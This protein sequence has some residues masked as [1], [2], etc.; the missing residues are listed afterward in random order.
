MEWTHV[1]LG[2]FRIASDRI[3]SN[4]TPQSQGGDLTTFFRAEVFAGREALISL[5]DWGLKHPDNGRG[6]SHKMLRL[7][8][9][10]AML[11][12]HCYCYFNFCMILQLRLAQIC[13]TVKMISEWIFRWWVSKISLIRWLD[14]Y[15]L[16]LDMTLCNGTVKSKK[17]F[18][19]ILSSREDWSA[20]NF[21]TLEFVC[22]V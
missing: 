10:S 19:F 7:K 21:S 15:S 9:K 16:S 11:R 14:N 2:I 17:Y 20:W 1:S 12:M 5:K 8:I 6:E 4:L 13:R 3:S 18:Y 22:E